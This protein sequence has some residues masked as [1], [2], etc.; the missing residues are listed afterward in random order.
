MPTTI[1]QAA[2][3]IAK[4]LDPFT[5]ALAGS[6]ADV[7]ALLLR[8]G[9]Q[10]PT[11]P[12]SVQAIAGSTQG[13]SGSLGALELALEAE[14]GGDGEPSA[15][16]AA[17]LLQ[18]AADLAAVATAIGDLPTQL[19]AELPANVVAATQIDAQFQERLF[20]T[21]V[22]EQI[23]G[24]SP[25][26]AAGLELL[27]LRETQAEDPDPAHF[28]PAFVRR[29]LHLDRLGRL[30]QDP[31]GLMRDVYGWGTPALNTERI[32]DALLGLSFALGMPGHLRYPGHEALEAL[33]PGIDVTADADH[34]QELVL[35]LVAVDGAGLAIGVMSGPPLAPGQPQPLV[36]T[37][38]VTGALQ[39]DVPLNP[40]T[41]LHV[42]AQADLSTGL[43]V[44]LRPGQAPE[45][46]FALG[47]P[48]ASALASGHVALRLN[49]SSGD[50][51]R[52]LRLLDISEGTRIE[53]GTL[54][55][56]AG[57]DARGATPEVTVEA[58]LEQGHFVLSPA[59]ADSFVSRLLPGDGLDAAFDLGIAWSRHGLTF[60]GS[61]G[62]EIDIG[63]HAQIGPLLL[64]T[65][66]LGI[67][68]AAPGLTLEASVTGGALIGPLTAIVD[69]VGA[70]AELGFHE[71][72]LGPVDLSLRFKPP[73]GIGLAVDA[74][75]V[76]GGGYLF[77]DPDKGEYAGVLEL[78]LKDIVQVKAIGLLATRMPD[79]TPGFS[80]L[81]IITGEFPPIQLGFGFTLTGVGGLVGV[82]RTMEVEA[83]RT[84]LRNHAL[85]SILFPDDPVRHAPQIISDLRAIFPP[86]EG[87]YVF[88]PMLQLGWGTP[89]LITAQ[90][91]VVLEVPDPVRLA[92]LGQVKAA[93]PT[94]DLP[95]VQL[96]MDVLGIIDFPG[97]K[98]SID[99]TLYDSSILVYALSGD[100]ALRLDWG[101]VPSFAISL[102]GL[103]PRFQ[104]PPGFPDL[105]RLTLSL[106]TGSNPRLSCE[107]YL[108]L[109]SN[110]LQFGSRVELYA[111]AAGFTVHGYLGFDVLIIFSPFSFEAEMQAGVDLLRGSTTLMS[112]HLDFILSGPTPWRA[113]G[114]ASFKILFCRIS[115]DFDVSWGD[116]DQAT[117]PPA[118]ARTP[119]LAALE[120]PRNWSAALP[121]G[122]EQG[123]SLGAGPA[124]E[125]ILVHPLGRL[126]VRQRI[127]PLGMTITRFG[128]GTPDHWNAFAI[129]DV[130]LNGTPASR[131]A[132]QDRFARG[133]FF[134]LSDDEKLSKPA[135]EA[136]DAGVRVGAGAATQGHRSPLELYYETKIVDDVEQPSRR[137]RLYAPLAEAFG[138]QVQL[139]AAAQSPVLTTGERKFAV[140]G[141]TGA[142]ATEE[143]RHTIASTEDLRARADLLGGV[144]ST[145][146]AVEQALVQHLAAHPEDAGTLQVL[147][148]HEAVSA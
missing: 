45:A 54:Y 98:L 96:H 34:P 104:P 132:V 92:I 30:L 127:A 107:S 53:A 142:V 38:L 23:E 120:D 112:I 44:V 25:L 76:K 8:L 140:P 128:S 137:F 15:Q 147:P 28:Q 35:P 113:R 5:D 109:T 85:N 17:A 119:L 64:D 134:E 36:T 9:W 111:S 3:A 10:L 29:T 6:T 84:G 21:L 16:V 88:G 102:G 61:A 130:D 89:T 121:E 12:P 97:K 83:L 87:R 75:V 125:G 141:V 59:G 4:A 42:D 68:V 118:D 65:V 126:T 146:S 24:A 131:E 56:G 41:S 20:H 33:A 110:S 82:N 62:T 72:N 135:F 74:G 11:V 124:P 69:R 80:L 73:N 77:L 7:D 103:H 136:M 51:T 129:T 43:S 37:L 79:G 39:G 144:A 60:R 100:M 13:L 101:D 114:E 123:V 138:A 95:L 47:G 81:L 117:L 139:G 99:A 22:D 50:P 31:I 116:D 70:R 93:L 32:F 71:G 148:L 86:A 49:R 19:R 57:V 106:G 94:E 26:L 1:E 2:L 55:V 14:V 27:A 145:R 40:R 58:G 105:R 133:Q 67:A 48:S 46:R 66:H 91:G 143:V 90:L 122:A 63:V 115:V 108:A 78:S 18:V 52:R